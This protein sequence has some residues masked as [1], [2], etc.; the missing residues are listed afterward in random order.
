LKG[1]WAVSAITSILI[2]GILGFFPS[3]L[4]YAATGD[5]ISSFDG[6]TDG[7]TQFTNPVG[8]TTDSTDRIIVADGLLNIVQIFDSTGS[9]LDSFDGT[10]GG[11]TQFDRL[12]S[13][14]TDS[15]DRIIVA[16]GLLKIVQIFDSTGSFLDSFNG[17]TG[18]GTQF[19]NPFA[20]TTDS[21]DRIIVAD[22][23]LDIVQI[24][25][26]TGSFVSSFNGTTGGGTQFIEPFGVTV[27]SNDRIILA[28]GILDTVQIFDS[29]GSFLDSF[30][31]TTGGGTQFDR[32]RSVT[33]DSNDRIIAADSNLDIVQIFDSTGSFLDSFDGTAGGGTQFLTPFSVTVDFNGRIIV[34]DTNLDLVQIFEGSPISDGNVKSIQKISDTQGGFTGVLDD[35]DQF[36]IDIS[37]L[38][39]LN[40]DG[41]PEIAVGASFDSD[42]GF[43]RGAVWILSLNSDGT[44]F[45]EQKI[46]DTQGNFMGDLFNAD[47]FGGS[48]ASIGDLDGDGVQDLVVGAAFAGSGGCCDKGAVWILFLNSDG[49]VKS[50]QE[51]AQDTG[52]FTG[53]LAGRG[54]FGGSVEGL[55]D[56]DGDGVEDIAVGN[57]GDND[58]GVGVCVTASP[59]PNCFRGAVWILFLNTD[60]TV[61][62]HQ[63]ISDTQGNFMGI[64]DNGDSIGTDV[65][66]IGDLDG[67]GV[68]DIAIGA[69]SDDDGGNG[70]GAIY[71]LFLNSDGTVKSEQKISELEGGFGGTVSDIGSFGASITPI[72]DLNGDGVVDIA[73]GTGDDTIALNQGSVW[74]LFMNS[75][76][77][78]ESEQ[79]IS[80]S[81][82]NF[83]GVLEAGD[84]FGISVGGIGDLDGD[85]I[86]D[87]AVGANND[88]DGGINRG[89]VWVL[90]MHGT[91]PA[92]P[93]NPPESE[94]WIITDSCEIS[95][96]IIAPASVIIQNDSVV[97]IN[98]GGSLT[99]LSG[100][101]LIIVNGSGLK[102]IQGSNLQVNS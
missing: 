80:S 12:R 10:T 79:E 56:L 61:K 2:L 1:I 4:A 62:S 30:D 47:L 45:S 100:E 43:A 25:D 97:T 13:V 29:T 77:T 15:A 36:G 8:A 6:T 65:T 14:T 42:G 99:I 7:G 67:D 40:G 21:T 89:A 63:K 98:S 85:G 38:G 11:G 91:L 83:P 17:T 48:V 37:N 49:T 26:S 35:S 66:N 32:L 92:I 3:Q 68:V 87:L 101:N 22:P 50:H 34:S 51:I 39:D 5:F 102:L 31:G 74:V 96:D 55:G 78:V 82:G 64:L 69:S 75:D 44:V 88:D 60:G 71:I 52:N 95:S 20:V 84:F 73:V 9:F 72:G 86:N 70:H 59:F 41:R 58:G 93:C 53:V 54:V 46:S 19:L 23:N 18:G 33:V 94:D 27:D 90:F 16:D 24:F 76:G 28:D 81:T 57:G